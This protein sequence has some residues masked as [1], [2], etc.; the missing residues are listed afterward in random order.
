MNPT[1]PAPEHDAAAPLAQLTE[2]TQ[3]L[4]TSLMSSIETLEGLHNRVR[5]LEDQQ[6]TNQLCI[7]KAMLALGTIAQGI[8]DETRQMAVFRTL[9]EALNEIRKP[10]ASGTT[11]SPV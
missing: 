2:I 8:G 5:L 9:E 4:T 10:G 3:S 7:A 6:R 1:T 11:G